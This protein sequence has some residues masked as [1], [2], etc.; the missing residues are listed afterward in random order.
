MARRRGT[1]IRTMATYPR[2]WRSRR[3]RLKQHQGSPSTSLHRQAHLPLHPPS[4]LIPPIA[5]FPVFLPHNRQN[6]QLRQYQDITHHCP[7]L[8]WD[9][10]RIVDR[11]LD[12]W[13]DE[14]SRPPYHRLDAGK[15]GWMYH[16]DCYHEYGCEVLRDVPVSPLYLQLNCI[17]GVQLYSG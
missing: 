6:T 10:L 4:T 8:D 5:E 1:G 7:G 12:V 16:C 2:H 17:H 9:I 3:G 13:T 15:H 11:H 14:R